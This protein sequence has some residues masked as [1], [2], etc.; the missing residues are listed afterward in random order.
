MLFWKNLKNK[1]R[2]DI[3]ESRSEFFGLCHTVRYLNYVKG[4]DLFNMRLEFKRNH[5]IKIFV[6]ESDAELWLKRAIFPIP[7]ENVEIPLK[8]NPNFGKRF[9]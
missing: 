7:M 4:N 1:S 5:D 9:L 8:S 2:F 3:R 6:H